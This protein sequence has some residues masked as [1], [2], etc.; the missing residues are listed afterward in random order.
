MIVSPAPAST[1][2]NVKAY[3]VEA[4]AMSQN[5][6]GSLDGLRALAVLSVVAFHTSR[7]LLGRQL[8]VGVS[9]F[10]VISGFLITTLLLRERDR[11]GA[12]NLSAFYAR[13]SLR[14]F[15]LYF[16][17][18]LVYTVV[19]LA[20]EHGS[21]R[22]DFIHNLPYFATYTNNWFV[23]L[24]KPRV[25]FYFAWSLATEEQFY[26]LWPSV[27]KRLGGHWAP[28]A[29]ALT[30]ASLQP[31]ILTTNRTSFGW[32]ILASIAPPICL[33]VALAH[34]LHTSQTAR[35]FF[36]QRWRSVFYLFALIGSLCVVD[37]TSIIVALI[38]TL[39]VGSC[40]ASE[41]HGLSKVLAWRPLVSIGQVSYGIYMMHML[42]TNVVER[43]P[44]NLPVYARIPLVAGLTW[45]MAWLSFHYYESR[46]LKLKTRFAMNRRAETHISDK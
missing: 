11:A 5:R 15:P 21:Y 31:W 24:D 34:V 28:I 18:L 36:A 6:F 22:A 29:V 41:D 25:I 13:R 38:S 43:A 2:F 20:H 16:S 17:M 7:G 3:S 35:S 44:I 14:I 30:L 10:F 42:I 19:V 37:H 12:I 33:G 45:G 1:D 40:V 4:H 39:L 26:L 27:E 32:H 46:F 8:A 23:P 9:I